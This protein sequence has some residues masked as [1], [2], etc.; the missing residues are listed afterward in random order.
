MM[1]E[2]LRLSPQSGYLQI[3]IV[4]HWTS[5][6]FPLFPPMTETSS[7]LFSLQSSFITNDQFPK[8]NTNNKPPVYPYLPSSGWPSNF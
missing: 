1:N 8:T 6:F 3:N 2:A 4:S 5:L 7:C